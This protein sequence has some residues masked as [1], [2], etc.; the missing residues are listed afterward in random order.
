MSKAQELVF[1]LLLVSTG[2]KQSLSHTYNDKD[3]EKALDIA[4]DQAIIGVLITAMEGIED[5]SLLPSKPVLFQ[6]IGNVSFIEQTAQK[7]EDAANEV[8]SFLHGNGFACQILKGI[9]V[10]RYYPQPH[11]RPSGTYTYPFP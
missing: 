5:K 10:A 8:I 3:W 1:E 11:R 4:D 6:W 2:A 9:A 7:M